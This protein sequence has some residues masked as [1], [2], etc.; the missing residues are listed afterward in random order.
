MPL[1]ANQHQNFAYE[2]LPILFHSQTTQFFEL[3]RR[4]GLKFLSFW[5]D[6]A[7]LN[8]DES[9]R[10]SVDGLDFEIKK[11]GDGR[12]M[13]LVKLP[14]PK[15]APEAY[16]LALI[17]RHKKRSFLPWRNYAKVFAL[18]RASDLDSTGAQ[19]T[20]LVELTR[21]ARYVPIGKGPRANMKD[22]SKAVTNIIT[23]K[24]KL[25]WL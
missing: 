24:L 4:D 16:Y 10:V 3:L 7:G 13:V 11:V 21:T 9:M 15:E 14:A 25:G 23:R 5:W 17:S 20:T 2:V 8:L 19:N 12:E 6:R 18:S 1:K 22:F